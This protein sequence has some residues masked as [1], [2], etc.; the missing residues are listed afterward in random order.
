MRKLTGALFVAMLLLMAGGSTADRPVS[1]TLAAA[2]IAD[3]TTITISIRGTVADPNLTFTISYD[4]K[5]REGGGGK[6]ETLEKDSITW[7]PTGTVEDDWE[8]LVVRD[9]VAEVNTQLS[10]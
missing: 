3:I 5:E 10:L 9:V 1:H 7:D 6:G 2:D 8:A 4:I